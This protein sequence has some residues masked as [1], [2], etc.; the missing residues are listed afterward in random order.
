MEWR[1]FIFLNYD[2]FSK[3]QKK[4]VET[5]FTKNAVSAQYVDVLKI[6][7]ES[8]DKIAI[9]QQLELPKLKLPKLSKV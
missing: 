7:Q 8:V 6:V 1:Q 5:N 2:K 9:P 4:F 3:E